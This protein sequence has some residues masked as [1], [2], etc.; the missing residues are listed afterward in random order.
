MLTWLTFA[1]PWGT[2]KFIKEPLKP[3]LCVPVVNVKI[4][5]RKKHALQKVKELGC[6]PGLKYQ[7]CKNLKCWEYEV[8]CP[9][10]IEVNGEVI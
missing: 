7:W 9:L 3:F 10:V 8:V 2:S 5:T 1:C 4:Y 6:A